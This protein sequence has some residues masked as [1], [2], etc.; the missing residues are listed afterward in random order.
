MNRIRKYNNRYQVL[1][2]PTQPFNPA[3]E[4]MMG[5]WD[6]SHLKNYYIVEYDTLGEAQCKAF[7][8]PDIDW[9]EMVLN[10]KSAYHDLKEEI[11]NILEKE[12]FIAD[13]TSNF[14]TPDQTKNSMFDRV[15]NNGER[16]A[17]V[18][19]MNDIIQYHISNPW[20]RNVTEIAKKL[21]KDPK[22]KIIKMTVHNGCITLVGKTSLGLTYEICVWTDLLLNWAKWVHLNP[23]VSSITKRNAF[24]KAMDQQKYL[25]NNNIIR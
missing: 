7:D 12:R 8:Y 6:D 9:R 21:S 11:K 18:F 4:I 20:S 16:F 1:I 24:V 5:G 13:V 10:Y 22:L 14:L 23:N 3:F 15:M 17:L 19:F 2:T 25:D